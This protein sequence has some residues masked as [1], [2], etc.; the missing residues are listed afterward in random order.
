MYGQTNSED[1]I[2]AQSLEASLSQEF[3]NACY[4]VNV[5]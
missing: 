1:V 5:V 2:S 4:G 3:F